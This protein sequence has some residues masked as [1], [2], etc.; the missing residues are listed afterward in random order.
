MTKITQFIFKLSDETL[1]LLV[2]LLFLD[3][4]VIIYKGWTIFFILIGAILVAPLLI[5]FLF[6]PLKSLF[7]LIRERY[8]S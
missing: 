2:V 8:I 1:A 3:I 6:N 5:K 7:G 4:V